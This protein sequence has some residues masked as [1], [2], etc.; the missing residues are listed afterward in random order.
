M[1]IVM[2]QALI[3]PALICAIFTSGV[4][5]AASTKLNSKKPQVKDLPYATTPVDTTLESL[6]PSYLG[7]SCRAFGRKLSGLETAKGEFEPTADYNDRM[8][9]LLDAQVVGATKVGDVVGFLEDS[10]SF[11]EK[12]DADTQIFSISGSWGL[13]N[14][15]VGS[16][17]LSSV[18]TDSKLVSSRKYI[19][20]NGF[21]RKAQVTSYL[22]NVCGIAFTNL[23]Y[24][25]RKKIPFAEKFDLTPA[26]AK[27]TKGNI[28]VLYV[29]RLEAPFRTQY[30]H[31]I[32]PTMDNPVESASS[33]DAL[34]MKLSAIWLFNKRTGR[35]Y[36]KM[37]VE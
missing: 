23:P 1:R 9:P 4:A 31:Y 25:S 11:Y 28:G 8:A 21:G 6:P 14:Q 16:E 29:G 33:G 17:L 13:I 18:T 10:P 32:K 5:H 20:E 30:S 36:R 2:R 26:D 27:E 12:Y 15:M 35:I 3:A 19:A 34:T 24:L 22:S 37:E 7:H